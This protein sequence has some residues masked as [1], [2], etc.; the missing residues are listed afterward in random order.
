M[1]ASW[2]Q[3]PRHGSNSRVRRDRFATVG[4]WFTG[5]DQA[6]AHFLARRE[7]LESFFAQ[8]EDD[9]EAV[10][11]G[12]LIVP[13]PEVKREALRVQSALEGVPGLELVPHHFLHVWIR[14]TAHGPDPS[15][16]AELT[17]FELEYRLLN[18]FHNAVVVEAT[19]DVFARV[20]APPTFLPHLTVAVVR[21]EPDPGPVR[22]AVEPLRGVELGSDLVEELVRVRFPASTTTIFQP[23][24]ML[25]R[26]GRR[27]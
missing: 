6:W 16:L 7:P 27:S 24:T 17:P 3:V 10:A 4:E 23:W 11:D 21:G 9:P 25:E 20:D 12:W 13:P 18:C 14:G 8:F 15:E 1:A 5:F 2:D 26:A 22:A 19:S